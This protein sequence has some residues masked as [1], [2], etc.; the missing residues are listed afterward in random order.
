[1]KYFFQSFLLKKQ[2]GKTHFFMK[3]LFKNSFYIFVITLLCSTA[4]FSQPAGQSG[5]FKISGK[6]TAD[7]ESL[8]G[9]T[10][11][12][13]E[14]KIGTT[15]QVGGDYLIEEVPAGN[16]NLRVNYGGYQEYKVAIKVTGE[17]ELDIN[18][19]RRIEFDELIVSATRADAKTPMTYTNVSKEELERNNLGQD[20]PFLLKYTPSV[21]V[22]SD[23][24]TGIG[25]TG[26]RVRG[27]DP[28]R[29][30]VTINGIPLNDS[31]SQGVFW[32]N[33]PDF[34][35]SVDNIQIQR[36]VGTSTNGAGAFGASI[37][38]NTSKVHEKAFAQV[39]NS[40]GSFNTLKN[41][42]QVGSGLIKDH[43][44]FDARLSQIQSD[45]FID[46]AEVDLQSYYLSAA[47]IADKTSIRFNTFSGHEVTYQAWNGVPAQFMGDGPIDFDTTGIRLNNGDLRRYNPSGTE[48]VNGAPH[49]N[50]VDDYRQTHYQALINHQFNSKL[51]VSGALHYTKGA[52]FFEQYKGGE[53]LVDYGLDNVAL[54]ND[55]ITSTD[56]IRRRWLDNDFYGF[57][58]ALKYSPAKFDFTLGGGWNFYQGKHFGEVIWAEYMSN[59]EQGH[60]YYDNDA[61]K[62][63]FNIFGKVNAELIDKLYGYLDLQ[64]RRVDYEFLGLDENGN[65]LA[66]SENLN[67]FNP[68]IG[69][70][71]EW[72]NNTQIYASFAVGNREPNRN[73]Y[74]ESSPTSRPVHET[75]Y[76][77]ELG[78]RQN[79]RGFA[80]GVNGYLMQY[81]NQLVLTG[82]I[83]DVGASTRVNVDDSYRA[84]IELEAAREITTG[85]TLSAN[86]TFSQNKIK[87]FTEFIDDW[88]TGGQIQ[89]EHEDTDLAFSPNTIFTAAIGYDV[90]KKGDNQQLNISLSGKHV[91]EQFLDNTSNENAMLD[92]FFYS[93]LR[94]GY[95]IKTK[96]VEEI[97]ITLLVRNIFDAQYANNG[98][99]YRYKSAGYDGR[100]DDPYARLESDGVYNLTGFFPQAGRN[101][102]L[103]VNLKF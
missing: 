51:N 70:T 79:F 24:G 45:G 63:D 86:A 46:R 94:I 55:T 80:W 7:G 57:T 75:L 17:M 60:R 26:I 82:E 83:N 61:E 81:N 50:E 1:V 68:K 52:G 13:A 71:Y 30:N 93:D 97:G 3:N 43:F 34:T 88:D 49:D 39:S 27:S 6:V 42:I 103:G 59:G 90:F 54:G 89:V 20:I 48:K 16:Y 69:L 72:H 4:G 14:L 85:L 41:N 31:E 10:I 74:T 5:G 25:Y 102:L 37:N 2:K 91:G 35:S 67:F 15:S 8:I 87:N 21:V 96:W 98:W 40:I 47:Y 84:G 78:I 101:F 73:D 95:S 19:S 99:T 44:T 18:I 12:V 64:F 92:A 36:G 32:V 77:T 22:S 62:T 76:N 66:T 11:Y 65:Q 58:Y 100:G 29:I 53:D 33:M 28:T 9:A 56:L 38:L 23:A